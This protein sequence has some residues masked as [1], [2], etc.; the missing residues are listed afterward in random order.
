MHDFS[1]FDARIR[2][3]LRVKRTHDHTQPFY[4]QGSKSSVKG[5]FEKFTVTV[6]VTEK[7]RLHC[8]AGAIDHRYDSTRMKNGISFVL[9]W[10][11][12]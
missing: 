2:S 3:N 8:V 7:K 4:H 1:T 5:D 10:P 9:N 6:P 11:L 12:E